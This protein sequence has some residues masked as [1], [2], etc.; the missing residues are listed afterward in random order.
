MRI[1]DGFAPEVKSVPDR[2]I[3]ELRASLR[4]PLEI[5]AAFAVYNDLR[6]LAR[7]GLF[8][9]G[10]CNRALGI[11]QTPRRQVAKTNQY[12]SSPERCYCPDSFFRPQVTCKHVIAA[13]LRERV[14]SIVNDFRGEL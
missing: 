13:R 12:G 2:E 5:G 6:R 9:A 4:F 14:D 7:L 10:R 1:I 3:P 8:D 11:V